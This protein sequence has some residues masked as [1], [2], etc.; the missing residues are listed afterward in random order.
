MNVFETKTSRLLPP[1]K[2]CIFDLFKIFLN[3]IFLNFAIPFYL[4][5]DRATTQKYQSAQTHYTLS[6]NSDNKNSNPIK[7]RGYNHISK[8]LVFQ[9]NYPIIERLFKPRGFLSGENFLFLVWCKTVP[10]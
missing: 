6:N 5:V 4:Q 3:E 2:K 7:N 9:D 10:C 1:I 8:T